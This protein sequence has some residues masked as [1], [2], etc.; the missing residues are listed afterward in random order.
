ML[1]LLG[2]NT[3]G[4]YA[5]R[6]ASRVEWPRSQIVLLQLATG[7]IVLFLV[8]LAVWTLNWIIFP[9]CKH[10][11]ALWKYLRGYGQWH[12]V[13]H[14]HGIRVFRPKWIGP[15]GKEEWTSGYVQNDVRGRGANRTR[16]AIYEGQALKRTC[17]IEGCNQE[18]R[19]SRNGLRLCKMHSNREKEER[20]SAGRPTEGRR[21][22][23]QGASP[24]PVPARGDEGPP[25][26]E[27]EAQTEVAGAFGVRSQA[28]LLTPRLSCVSPAGG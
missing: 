16:T 9:L 19:V 10:A 4:R 23:A 15:R 13:A 5:R 7:V 25:G 18:V 8:Q 14:L 20:R 27:G 11:W 26:N 21:A 28:Q 22:A 2:S 17:A 12:E 6:V 3:A 24:S 1:P